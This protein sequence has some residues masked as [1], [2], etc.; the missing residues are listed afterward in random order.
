MARLVDWCAVSGGGL[1]DDLAVREI[2]QQPQHL[3]LAA[4][5]P[6]HTATYR[7]QASNTDYKSVM[8]DYIYYTSYHKM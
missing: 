2:L 3:R 1:D 8:L 6:L 7:T 5:R 4:D